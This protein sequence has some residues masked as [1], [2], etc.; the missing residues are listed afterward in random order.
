MNFK[1][2]KVFNEFLCRTVEIYLK[3]PR[4][5]RQINMLTRFLYFET[6]LAILIT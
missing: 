4:K 6:T 2:T 3:K 1:L 5:C